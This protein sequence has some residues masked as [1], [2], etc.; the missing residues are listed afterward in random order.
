MSSDLPEEARIVARI[1][2]GEVG[3]LRVAHP[4][5]STTPEAGADGDQQDDLNAEDADDPLMVSE[6]TDKIFTLS[7]L[8]S[9][10]EIL[11]MVVCLRTSRLVGLG[12][13]RQQDLSPTPQAK[14]G[15]VL[16]SDHLLS[17]LK[18]ILHSSVMRWGEL[19]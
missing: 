13:V 11:R 15:F 4:K 14:R 1:H 7:S 9:L 10:G 17:S 8:M 2:P 18:I 6:Y 3:E 5:R 19:Q 16:S 12:Q